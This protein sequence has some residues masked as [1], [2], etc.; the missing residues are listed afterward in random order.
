MS[1]GQEFY[2]A[3]NNHEYIA[4][5]HYITQEISVGGLKHTI[6]LLHAYHTQTGGRHRQESAFIT[7]YGLLKVESKTPQKVGSSTHVCKQILFWFA[8]SQAFLYMGAEVGFETWI[9]TVVSNV[10][11]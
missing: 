4:L 9:V 10:I 6:G 1:K 3:F 7:L 2:A 11:N 8:I 5:Y